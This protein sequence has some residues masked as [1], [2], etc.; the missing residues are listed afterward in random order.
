MDNALREFVRQ[1]ANGCCEYCRM[2]QEE[3]DVLPFQI[4]HI[5]SLKHRGSSD[6]SIL[7]FHATTAT[8]IKDLI[9]QALIQL[10]GKS[11][12]FFTLVVTNGMTIFFGMNLI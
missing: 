3:Y 2:P 10:L 1:R 7:P 5:I 12:A 8:P 11:L 4:D 6:A 9:L